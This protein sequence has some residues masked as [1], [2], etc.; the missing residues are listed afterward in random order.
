[1]KDAIIIH[2]RLGVNIGA[3]KFIFNGVKVMEYWSDGLETPGV[4]PRVQGERGKHIALEMIR[5]IYST[6]ILHHS[7]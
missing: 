7:T 2:F 6:P 1:L 5:Q 4:R 3:E